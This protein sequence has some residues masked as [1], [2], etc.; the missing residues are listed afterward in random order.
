MRV[1]FFRDVRSN[2]MQVRDVSPQ[3]LLGWI[4]QTHAPT[5]H[6]LPLL[7]LAAFGEIQSDK[8]LLR[9]DANVVEVYG[10]ECDY[11]D[12]K[13]PYEEAVEAVRA[14][15]A[16][17]LLYTSPSH[18]PGAPRW[19]ALFPL[20]NSVPPAARASLA[21]RANAILG[22]HLSRETW[23]LSQIFY[24]GRADDN[25]HFEAVYLP[26]DSLN[27]LSAIA[28]RPH[29]PSTARKTDEPTAKSIDDLSP[30]IKRA[31]KS[32]DPAKFGFGQDRSRLVFSVACDLVR[33]GWDDDRIAAVLS[34]PELPISGHV[35]DQNDPRRYA[36]RQ[37]ADARAKVDTGWTYGAAGQII[38]DDQD[39][40][41][42]A[43]DG[44]G[45]RLSYD[46]FAM[47]AHVNGTAGP[48]REV[49][50]HEVN[51]IRLAIDREYGFRPTKDFFY[52][53]VDHLSRSNSIHPVDEYLRPL[54]HDNIPRIGD[55]NTPGWLTTYGGV[56]DSPYVR[57]ISR[58][59]L[60]AAV[61]RIRKPGC[62][63]DE[64]V[65]LVDP[66]QGTEKS[67][68]LRTLAVR[69]EWF[70]DALPLHADDKRVIEQLRG[71]WIIEFSE[72]HGM[73][74]R[75]AEALKAFLARQVDSARL[76]YGRL[77][78]NAPRQCV[79]FGTTNSTTFLR[80][81]ENRRYWPVRT[82][83][84]DI[85]SLARDVDQ[86]WAEAAAAEAAGESIRLPRELWPAAAEVQAAHRQEEP[87]VEPLREVLGDMQGKILTDDVWKIVDK[88]RHQRTQ[89][90]NSRMGE[91]MRELGW[92][93]KHL[94]I[95]GRVAWVYARGNDKYHRRIEIIYDRLER[96]ATAVYEDDP[97]LAASLGRD[98]TQDTF[99]MEPPF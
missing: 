50:D 15:G 89:G 19:R 71:R 17:A 9:H 25:P 23:A 11:D 22:G 99:P 95:A 39:N 31:I 13:T 26:G 42:R 83:A 40:V 90:D 73:G 96:T 38:A 85:A 28:G 27:S 81:A 54:V 78:T 1:T 98:P 43:V 67:T 87:W 93:R 92:T 91:A 84:F 36:L 41:A 16:E 74:G 10:V 32:G 5:K 2:H 34:D 14:A 57:A 63:F 61:R 70:S 58:L 21:D 75:D 68:A 72:L 64:M 60:V 55:P 80:D 12:A 7:K 20:S 77:N 4:T 46:V 44:L 51:E 88:P 8:G 49:D 79:F 3:A 29:V 45:Y 82:Q 86:L 48:R 69:D 52:D 47:K 62:K 76:A 30:R 56:D 24:Y 94:R 97:A 59:V 53:M 18:A 33:A 6:D 65:V 35:R 37:A 66:K